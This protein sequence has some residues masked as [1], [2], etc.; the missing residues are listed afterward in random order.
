[1]YQIKSNNNFLLNSCYQILKQINFPITL[2]DDYSQYGSIFLDFNTNS[3]TIKYNNSEEKILLPF[4]TNIFTQK[5]FNL[6]QDFEITFDQLKYNPM[7]E[8]ISNK[9]SSLKLRNTH[10]LILREALKF[11]NQ[12]INKVDLYKKIWP[13]DVDIQINKLDTHL[14]NLK[15]LFFE[16]F[17][18]KLK[19]KSNQ[20][21]ITFLIN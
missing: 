19:F 4:D 15:N 1:M 5:I 20:G 11:K 8:T 16:Y 21:K 12:G 18:Y 7:K 3:L 14:T 17:S 10:N 13:N 6:L 2:N 9:S